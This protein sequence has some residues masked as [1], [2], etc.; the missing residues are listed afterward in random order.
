[1]S[2]VLQ[3]PKQPQPPSPAASPSRDHSAEILFF[4]GVRIERHTGD[5]HQD[6]R[7]QGRG[8]AGGKR[9]RKA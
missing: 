1:M 2:I 5:D 4:T 8:S 3:F 9:H 6:S 7:P